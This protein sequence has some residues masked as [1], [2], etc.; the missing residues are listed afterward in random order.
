MCIY[1]EE[2]KLSYKHVKG[3]WSDHFMENRREKSGIWD[4]YYFLGFQNHCGW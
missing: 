2:M 3:I 4:R 1:R